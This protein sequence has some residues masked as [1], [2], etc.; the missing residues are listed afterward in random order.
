MFRA[1][2]NAVACEVSRPMMP[3]RDPPAG[4]ALS[5]G[6]IMVTGAHP[7]RAR[8]VEELRA[9]LDKAYSLIPGRHRLNLHAI[10]GESAGAMIDR[11]AIGLGDVDAGAALRLDALGVLAVVPMRL[12][13][14]AVG[15]GP[16]GA[17]LDDGLFA[18]KHHFCVSCGSA[19]PPWYP[20][21]RPRTM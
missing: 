6:G 16:A 11:D 8:T 20:R 1:F 21:R 13:R 18:R 3:T 14:E 17:I 7:G 4:A 12:L 15:Y 2:A 5:G 19:R 9:D 10:Y